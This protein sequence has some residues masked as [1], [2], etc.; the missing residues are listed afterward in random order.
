VPRCE[1]WDAEQAARIISENLR[2]EGATLPILHALQ[3]TFGHVPEAAV[4]MVADA[5]N[6][7]RAEVHGVVTFYHDFRSE[8]PG[9][10]VLKLCRAEACQAAGG[11]ALA[12]A[13]QA[14]LGINIGHTTPDGRVTLE[15]V[16]CLGLCATAP[17]AMLDDRVVGRLDE[18]RLSA[19][20]AEAQQ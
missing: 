3:E 17:S 8:P 18:P 1:P 19:L 7:S 4:R 2:H 10:R 11:D 12:A 9:R 5:L 15:A 13:A 14:R 6:L 16:Y 20:L